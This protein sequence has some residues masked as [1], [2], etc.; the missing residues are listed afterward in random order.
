MVK[1][2]GDTINEQMDFLLKEIEAVPDTKDRATLRLNLIKML[3]TAFPSGV[4][5][6]NNTETVKE[7]SVTPKK[8]EAKENKPEEVH[9]VSKREDFKKEEKVIEEEEDPN[10][11]TDE[12][13]RMFK[14]KLEY[15][16]SIKARLGEDADKVIDDLVKEFSSNNLTSYD[17]IGPLN[18]VAFATYLKSNVDT[19]DDTN[20]E[21]PETV[22][23]G[24]TSEAVTTWTEETL[25][26]FKNEIAYIQEIKNTLGDDANQL[27]AIVSEYSNGKITSIDDLTPIDIKGFVDFLK[28][29]SEE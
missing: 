14:D 21:K 6:S 25:E 17:E 2:I 7:E 11:W 27:N 1:K 15:V 9:L 28:T 20:T 12:A 16:E 10:A 18:I 13:R 3:L 19:V 8:E 22:S 29:L 23:P 26:E 24:E 5:V 4:A